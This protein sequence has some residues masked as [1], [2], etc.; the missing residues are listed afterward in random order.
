M[1]E[2]CR[3]LFQFVDFNN[4]NMNSGILSIA[5]RPPLFARYVGDGGDTISRWRGQCSSVNRNGF[6]KNKLIPVRNST[7]LLL[8]LRPRNTAKY[9]NTPGI[10]AVALT[11][12]ARKPSLAR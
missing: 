3:N 7:L 8:P 11:C 10:I 4:F 5:G 1:Y 12:R 9:E 2:F 6:A